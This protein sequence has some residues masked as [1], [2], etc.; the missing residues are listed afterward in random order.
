[1]PSLPDIPGPLA[2]LRSPTWNL[3][4][5][6]GSQSGA[7]EI[8]WQPWDRVWQLIEHLK[9]GGIRMNVTGG[10]GGSKARALAAWPVAPTALPPLPR[11]TSKLLC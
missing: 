10:Q 11:P 5:E 7:K 9:E 4:P 6:T 3:I 2:T 1:M 8:G